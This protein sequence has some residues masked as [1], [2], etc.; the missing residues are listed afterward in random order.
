MTIPTTN[1]RNDYVGNGVAVTYPYTFK[2]F[3]SSELRVLVD[4][5]LQ[6][7]TTHYTVTGV[8]AESGGNVVFVTAP[9]NGVS[10]AIL[11]TIPLTQTTDL[12]NETG[13]F[14]DRIEQRFDKLCRADQVTSEKIGRQLTIPEDEAGSALLTELPALDDRKG[15]TLGFDPSTGQ[16]GAYA[17][18][19]TTVSAAMIPVVQ[20]ATQAAAGDAFDITATGGSAARSLS[21]RFADTVNVK[22]YASIQAAITASAVGGLVEI[23]P[24]AWS[25]SGSITI[26]KALTLRGAGAQQTTITCTAAGVNTG[27]IDITASDVRIEGISLIGPSSA[28]YVSRESGIRAVGSSGAH[29]SDIDVVDCEVSAFGSDGI[30]MEYVDRFAVRGC[31]VHDCGYAGIPCYSCTDGVIESNHIKTIT[32]GTS[33]NAYG[34]FA[35]Q[36]LDGDARCERIVFSR[37]IVRDIPLWE[38]LDTHGGRS[39]SFIGNHIEGCHFGI[40]ATSAV[41]PTYSNSA[42]DIAIIGNIIRNGAAAAPG[43]GIVVGGVDSTHR[44]RSA[45]VEGN[46]VDGMGNVGSTSYGAVILQYVA[47]V[48]YGGVIRNSRGVA[49]NI[50]DGV[51][52]LQ[53]DVVVDGVQNGYANAAGIAL[54]V[55]NTLACTGSINAVVDATAEYA[56]YIHTAQRGVSWGKTKFTTSNPAPIIG[57][58]LAGEGLTLT[59]TLSNYNFAS[60]SS[61]SYDYQQITVTGA[62]IGDY[63][64][65]GSSIDIAKL[66]LSAYV[67]SA[68]TVHFVL[69][70][71]TGGN[72]DL[73]QA[74]YSAK[75]VKA[76]R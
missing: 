28:T 43:A 65:V 49:L 56:L 25:V 20:A 36:R 48:R 31:I 76:A 55:G 3:A 41:A 64:Q 71:L 10:V 57:G 6:T 40:V 14:Q 18:S 5:V 52:N 1:I 27:A 39:I 68:N 15:M 50:Y 30:L 61:G 73:A 74:N 46:V 67:T 58:N 44:A 11:A 54:G 75:V 23:P 51:T 66:N 12:V 17:M 60:I 38:A 22:D 29:L 4:G 72:V 16:P 26:N 34:A 42:E 47:G 9:A 13:F 33:G 37:N 32:P 8:G 69:Y 70:N 59:G 35:S 24:G 7:L 63:V 62:E 21:D 2:V 19:S 53:A 45:T